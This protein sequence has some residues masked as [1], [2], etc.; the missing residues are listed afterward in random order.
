LTPLIFRYKEIIDRIFGMSKEI[1]RRRLGAQLKQARAARGWRLQ[2]FS[3]MTGRSPA[4]LSEMETG[5][6]NSSLDS[7]TDAGETL[8]MSLVF[9]PMERLQDVLA[10]TGQAPSVRNSATVPSVYDEVFVDDSIDAEVPSDA[11]P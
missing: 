11:G 10:M 4:R 1:S 6:A 5:T 2:D 9:V 7:L 8:G 3:R